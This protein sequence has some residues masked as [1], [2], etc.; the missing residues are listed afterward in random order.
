MEPSIAHGALTFYMR[1]SERDTRP[2][3][4]R[5]Q[6]DGENNYP[7]E[8]QVDYTHYE[9]MR[10]SQARAALNLYSRQMRQA[11]DNVTREVCSKETERDNRYNSQKES[12]IKRKEIEAGRLDGLFGPNSPTRRQLTQKFDE[13]RSVYYQA[14]MEVGRPP[15]TNLTAPKFLGLTPYFLLLALLSVLESP[16][17]YYTVASMFGSSVA[18]SW[19]LAAFVGAIYMVLAHMLGQML[20]HLPSYETGWP[21][22]EGQW[23]RRGNWAGIFVVVA[24]TVAITV[25]LFLLRSETTVAQAGAAGKGLANVVLQN[26]DNARAA[27]GTVADNVINMLMDKFQTY[28]KWALLVMNVTVFAIGTALSIYRHDPHPNYEGIY[29]RQEK[30]EADL[31][32]FDERYRSQS[33]DINRKYEAQIGQVESWADVVGD[34]ITRLQQERKRLRDQAAN[35]VGIVINVLRQQIIAYQ[36]GNTETRRTKP[37]GYFGEPSLTNIR[38]HL[39]SPAS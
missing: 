37:P 25:L 29:R 20:R 34:D 22:H 39:L 17:N 13:A 21:S 16:I 1:F 19:V 9:M 7:P 35:D 14:F 38:N 18:A 2:D 36:A 12:F 26:T 5:G 24:L 31:A 28:P 30:A 27:A 33:A 8:V 32:L 4:M 6:S 10:I 23:R 3:Y 15:I 11:L